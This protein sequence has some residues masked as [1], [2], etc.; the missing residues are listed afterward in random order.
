MSIMHL[1]ARE[2]FAQDGVPACGRRRGFYN[3]ATDGHRATHALAD[4]TCKACRMTREFK[5]AERLGLK[6]NDETWQEARLKNNR[7]MTVGQ[8][9]DA[10]QK[11]NAHQR[12]IFTESTAGDFDL[13]EFTGA[14][15]SEDNF[16]KDLRPIFRLEKRR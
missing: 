15:L 6:E 1:A 7:A 5:R 16:E 8:L 10:L 3:E 11:F 2:T 12:L 14:Y 9:M 13:T 4:V